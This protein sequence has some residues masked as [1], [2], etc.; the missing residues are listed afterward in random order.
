[1]NEHQSAMADADYWQTMAPAG[2]RLSGWTFRRSALYIREDGRTS[3]AFELN[4]LHVAWMEQ[5]ICR[6]PTKR[7]YD[8]EIVEAL[9][10]GRREIAAERDALIDSGCIKDHRGAPIMSTMIDMTRNAVDGLDAILRKFDAALAKA[11]A[12]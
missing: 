4:A 10:E 8:P 12:V 7:D 3:P 9:R 5:M 6:L 2:Y 11:G 1:M